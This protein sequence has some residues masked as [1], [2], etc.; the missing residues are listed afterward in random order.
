MEKHF[1]IIGDSWARTACGIHVT[2]LYPNSQKA[3]ANGDALIAITLDKSK[4]ECDR[5]R[6]SNDNVGKSK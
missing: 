2:C 1:L 4:V 6:E 5:C 3:L